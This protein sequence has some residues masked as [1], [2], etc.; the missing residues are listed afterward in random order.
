MIVARRWYLSTSIFRP[1]S[2]IAAFLFY[3]GIS[4]RGH[5]ET[6]SPEHCA[7]EFGIACLRCQRYVAVV[8]NEIIII[9]L[10]NVEIDLIKFMH[11]PYNLVFAAPQNNGKTILFEHAKWQNS[12][13]RIYNE[14]DTFLGN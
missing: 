12:T 3:C 14:C 10:A 5:Y 13:H 9:I 7:T 1:V 8:V 6:L 4:I 11:T 2:F